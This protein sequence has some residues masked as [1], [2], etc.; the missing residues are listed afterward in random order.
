M[1]SCCFSSTL[2]GWLCRDQ[3][4]ADLPE[5]SK[6]ST[7]TSTARARWRFL[8]ATA[9]GIAAS[10]VLFGLIPSASASGSRPDGD[11]RGPRVAR[12]GLAASGPMAAPAG[13]PGMTHPDRDYAGSEIAKHE[14]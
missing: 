6:E 13:D 11:D 5:R 3:R 12:G 4:P 8:S 7:M 1:T 14:S 2:G 10:T 9:I